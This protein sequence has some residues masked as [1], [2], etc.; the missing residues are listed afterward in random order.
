MY[1]SEHFFEDV[2]AGSTIGVIVTIC[3]ITW[4]MNVKFLKSVGWNRGLLRK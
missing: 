1:L 4:L 3:L 2:T